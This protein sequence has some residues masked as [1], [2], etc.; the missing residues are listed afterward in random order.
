MV[1]IDPG[2]AICGFGIVEQASPG[3][4]PRAVRF[5]VFR[6]KGDDVARLRTIYDGVQA[7]I[8]DHRPEAAAVERVYHNRN[9]STAS[10]VGQARGVVLLAFGQAGIPVSE[11]TPTE[12]KLAV[13]GYG[14]AGKP[15]VQAMVAA[16]L[17][18][19]APPS[20]DDAADALGLCLCHLAGEGLRGRVR[21][22]SGRLPR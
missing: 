6:P 13:A 7:L 4:R 15:Q 14:G 21:A 1:G 2:T 11:Y 3:A 5:G 22:L 17:G 8:A 18:L 19:A 10:S 9:V 12:M 16:Q 20:P